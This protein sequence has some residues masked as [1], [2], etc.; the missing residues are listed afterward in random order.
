MKVDEGQ[1]YLPSLECSLSS[2]NH[3]FGTESVKRRKL[4]DPASATGTTQENSAALRPDAG[5]S[6]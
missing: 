1:R 3:G 4:R 2:K 5:Q 6:L